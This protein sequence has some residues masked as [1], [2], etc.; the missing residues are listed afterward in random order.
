MPTPADVDKH[1]Q[2]YTFEKGLAKSSGGQG[3]A[4]VWYRGHFAWEYKGPNKDLDRAYD[5]LLRYKDHLENPPL[6]VV[7]DFDGTLAPIAPRRAA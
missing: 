4:D 6:L 5:Q 3:W 7:S 2:T 1:G